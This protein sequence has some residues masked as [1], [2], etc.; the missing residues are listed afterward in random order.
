MFHLASLHLHL[1]ERDSDEASD[2]A[3]LQWLQASLLHHPG[4]D[5]HAP[6]PHLSSTPHLPP[7]QNERRTLNQ[8]LKCVCVCFTPLKWRLAFSFTYISN[9]ICLVMHKDVGRSGLCF[10]SPRCES[11]I[12]FLTNLKIE[13]VLFCRI[14]KRR[15]PVQ[16]ARAH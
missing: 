16:P 1:G 14:N 13:F 2:N 9:C 7:P 10:F 15:C 6:P 3:G 8:Q 11:F 4:A 12:P 5:V